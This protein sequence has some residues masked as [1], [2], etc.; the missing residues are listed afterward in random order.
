MSANVS[1]ADFAEIRW[2]GHWIWVS[3][4]K[5]EAAMGLGLSDESGSRK[6]S[7]GLFRKS[8]VLDAVPARVPGGPGRARLARGHWC[9]LGGAGR[10]GRARQLLALE[11]LR[12][13]AALR[14]DAAL[15]R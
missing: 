15:C 12:M 4:D 5:V 11:P 6:E 1:A 9:S 10:P 13:A 2:K 14:R 8:F 7:N 3:E